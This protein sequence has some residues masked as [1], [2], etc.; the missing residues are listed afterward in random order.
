MRIVALLTVRNEQRHLAR[1]LEHLYSQ[2]IETCLIDNGSTDSTLEIAQSFLSR[3]VCRIEHFPFNGCFELE[4]ILLNEERLAA[5]IDADWLIHHDADEIRQAPSQYKTLKEGIEDAD[6]QG[7]NAINFDEFVFLPTSDEEDFEGKDYVKEMQYY[8]FFE[9]HPL[10]RLNAWK[11][12]VNIDLHSHAGHRIEFA[13]RK[14]FPTEFILRHYIVLSKSHALQ[15]YSRIYSENRI[16]KWGHNERTLFKPQ[17]LNF[18]SKARLKKL[19]DS[20]NNWDKSDPWVQHEIFISPEERKLE[21]LHSR[22]VPGSKLQQIQA[23]LE[24]SHIQ[25]AKLRGKLENIS[26]CKFAPNRVDS[27]LH[28]SKYMDEFDIIN[29]WFNRNFVPVYFCINSY[30]EKHGI[31]GNLAE[32]G[33]YHGKSFIPLCC[34]CK[35]GELALAVDIFAPPKSDYKGVIGNRQIFLDNLE[36]YL[37]G[38]LDYIKILQVNSENCTSQDYLNTVQGKKMRIFSVDGRH[39]RDA[40]EIDLRNAYNCLI[41]GGVIILDDYF[42]ERTP[43]VSEG[44]YSFLSKDHP[45]IKACFIGY[46][47]IILTHS[48]HAEGYM[49]AFRKTISNLIQSELLGSPVLIDLKNNYGI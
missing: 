42:N 4:K 12:T 6:R 9:P 24:R 33:I 41:K 13:D 45:D 5:E 22:S 25:L 40:T 2:G 37:S 3:G 32:I 1:C 35:P 23:D 31:Q 43:G 19:N 26:N 27:I 7:Y 11:K 28:L 15:K 17:W 48:S 10:R 34:L 47:K 21:T 29:G 44:F 36:K 30:Q 38:P 16:K 39:T 49:S 14:I 20:G 46:N 8:Y 18:P